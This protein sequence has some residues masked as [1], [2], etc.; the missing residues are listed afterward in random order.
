MFNKKYMY[1]MKCV[2]QKLNNL[3]I[4]YC[5]GKITQKHIIEY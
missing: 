3:T 2:R 5:K 4:I 1:L